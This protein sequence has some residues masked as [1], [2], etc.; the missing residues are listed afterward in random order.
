M[1]F[2]VNEFEPNFT[3]FLINL[4]PVYIPVLH[5]AP[6]LSVYTKTSN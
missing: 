6:P 5:N 4:L 2:S 1:N 3:L